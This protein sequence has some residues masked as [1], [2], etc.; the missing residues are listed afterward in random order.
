MKKKEIEKLLVKAKDGDEYARRQL[1]SYAAGC[2]VFVL[3]GGELSLRATLGAIQYRDKT[4]FAPDEWD[5]IKTVTFD[6]AF[7][8]KQQLNP[9]TLKPV[10]P[11]TW[12]KLWAL[13][14]GPRLVAT[15]YYG[16]SQGHI[17]AS[18]LE[19]RDKAKALLAGHPWPLLESVG[20]LMDKSDNAHAIAAVT[21]KSTSPPAP[22]STTPHSAPTSGA[23]DPQDKVQLRQMMIQGFN[24][25]DIRTLCFDLG[26][27]YDDL[28]GEGKSMKILYLIDRMDR[29]HQLSVLVTAVA[30]KNPSRFRMH[31]G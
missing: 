18:D 19:I 26:V 12:E 27:D 7:T 22:E 10:T 25:G 1:R 28:R 29:D 8:E 14:N 20:A 16:K 2:S 6:P 15:I 24:G 31:F 5:D 11:G 21:G 23:G 9:L 17:V 4:G 30:R 13:K 3:D